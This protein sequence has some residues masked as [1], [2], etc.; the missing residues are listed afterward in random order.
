MPRNTV[1]LEKRALADPPAEEIANPKGAS[2]RTSRPEEP[3]NWCNV[4]YVRRSIEMHPDVS[5]QLERLKGKLRLRSH[6]DVLQRAVQLLDA[7]V[8]EQENGLRIFIESPSGKME[9]V[10][11]F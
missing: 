7:I 4:K 3:E 5:D 1:A 6:S 10:R 9:Q 8:R 2:G 11:V